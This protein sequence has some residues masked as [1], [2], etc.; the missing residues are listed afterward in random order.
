MKL[1]TLALC[2]GLCFAASAE[3]KPHHECAQKQ[4]LI[5]SLKLN[6]DQSA[7]LDKLMAKHREAMDKLRDQHEQHH[8]EDMAEM[9]KL[10]DS[11]RSD[12]ATILTPSQ[13]ATFDKMQQGHH[14]PRPPMDDQFDDNDK[15]RAE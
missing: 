10:W 7:K 15:P 5:S 6:A 9:K 2:L 3:A 13:L 1:T 8:R 14:H 11:Q 12:V 4:D